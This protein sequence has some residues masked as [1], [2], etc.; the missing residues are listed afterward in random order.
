MSASLLVGLGTLVPSQ[1]AGAEASGSTL[2]VADTSSVQKLDPDV[3]TNF[4]DFQTLGLIYDQLVQYNGT[5]QLVPD[6][7][8]KW[9]YSNGNKLLTFQL[10]QGVTFDDGTAFTSANVVASLDRALA[11]KT[12]DASASYLANVKK[13]GVRA[14]PAGHLDPGRAYIGQPVDVVDQGDRGWDGGQDA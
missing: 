14:E 4:L 5:L 2:V 8:T 13:R 3:V 9:T 10:R 12:G 11:P 7:A 1:V 6:L